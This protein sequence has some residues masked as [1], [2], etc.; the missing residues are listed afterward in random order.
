M[1]AADYDFNLTRTQIIERALRIVGA[2]SLGESM[3][4]EQGEQG[5][6]ALNALLKEW[7]NK[8]IFLWSQVQLTVTLVNADK[9]YAL[10]TDPAVMY[11]DKAYLRSSGNEDTRL[12]LVSFRDYEEIPTKNDTGDPVKVAID[13]QNAPTLYVWPIPT[14]ASILVNP[15]IMYLATVKGRDLDAVSST[16]D[17]HA[18]CL[19]AL[20]YGLAANLCDEYGVPI[21]ERQYLAVKAEEKFQRIKGSDRQRE[22]RTFVEGA[23]PMRRG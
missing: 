9:D 1:A 3:R 17:T 8:H 5:Q 6:I 14:T 15:T 23:F 16:P 4:D 7:Q 10:S 2:L 13:Y 11:V 20:C 19:D 12:D 18:R 22:D 21:H